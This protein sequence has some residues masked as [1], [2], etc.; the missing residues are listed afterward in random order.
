M[1]QIDHSVTS[2]DELRSYVHHTL[3]ERES[4]LAEQF[5]TQE[6]PLL[7]RGTLCG[8]Q[9]TLRG[10]RAIKLG[11]IWAAEQ[12]VLFFYDTRGERYLRVNL[13]ERFAIPELLAEAG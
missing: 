6:Q 12:N 3:C 8:L 13:V 1:Q 4:L 2:V 11:A 9:F 5:R 7:S 10:P